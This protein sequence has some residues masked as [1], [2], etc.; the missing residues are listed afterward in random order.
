MNKL[1]QTF[2]QG[3]SS[4]IS[5]IPSEI[6]LSVRLHKAFKI[7]YEM[8]NL[9]A[10]WR[11]FKVCHFSFDHITCSS[12]ISKGIQSIFSLHFQPSIRVWCLYFH[13]IAIIQLFNYTFLCYQLLFMPLN[14]SSSQSVFPSSEDS[15]LVNERT[16][17]QFTSTKCFAIYSR[18][19]HIK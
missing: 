12:D 8:T 4:Y 7:D 16:W 15:I 6:L 3:I 17:Q 14:F 1:T 9:L 13:F 2:C 19:K 5:E 18:N 11:F 10:P